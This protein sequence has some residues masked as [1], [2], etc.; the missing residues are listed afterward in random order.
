M[1][2]SWSGAGE[3]QQEFEHAVFWVVTN[4][5]KPGFGMCHL[6]NRTGIDPCTSIWP[7]VRSVDSGNVTARVC[8]CR[9]RSALAV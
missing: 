7:E 6:E 2:W 8:P 3:I 9:V 1:T 5:V 4:P